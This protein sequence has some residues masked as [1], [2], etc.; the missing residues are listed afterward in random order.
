MNSL[1][2]YRAIVLIFILLI[3][4]NV[5]PKNVEEVVEDGPYETGYCSQDS[6]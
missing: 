4:V 6:A 3:Y 5:V 2:L 1:K